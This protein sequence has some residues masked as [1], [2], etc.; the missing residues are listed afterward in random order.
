MARTVGPNP[1]YAGSP[2]AGVATLVQTNIYYAYLLK[3]PNGIPFYVGKGKGRRCYVHLKPWHLKKDENH[4]KVNVIKQI[5]HDG[6]E[7]VVEILEKN[8]T[9]VDAFRIETE[10]IKLYG[11]VANG[12]I[13]VNMTDGGEGQ[14]G[15]HLKESTKKKL[16]NRNRRE[17]NPF[18][19]KKHTTAT[20][21]KIGDTN[22]GKTLG[23]DWRQKLSISQKGHPKSEETKRKMR[24]SWIGRTVSSE[25]KQRLRDLNR[26]RIGKS[27]SVEQSKKISES[28]RR[29]KSMGLSVGRPKKHIM[30]TEMSVE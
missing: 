2:P 18:F 9:E 22:R 6:G 5:R 24:S 19:G 3:R 4:L 28:L 12:G 21:R 7:P 15:F 8:L 23:A 16:S 20:L 13:L 17:G 30:K 29:R 25:Q 11:R 27:L 10:Q 1:T 26:S 14:S